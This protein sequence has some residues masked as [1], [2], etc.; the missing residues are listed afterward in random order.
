MYGTV[1]SLIFKGASE[2][3]KLATSTH[4]KVEAYDQRL[5]NENSKENGQNQHR[6]SLVDGSKMVQ[7]TLPPTLVM[8]RG[9]KDL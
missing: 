4:S 7:V 2:C 1:I 8:A 9:A 5:I 6:D 3:S